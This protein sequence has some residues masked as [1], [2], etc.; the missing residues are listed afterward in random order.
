MS[1]RSSQGSLQTSSPASSAA[2]RVSFEKVSKT[3]HGAHGAVQVVNDVSFSLGEGDFVSLI[4]PSGCGKTTMLQMLAGF[5]KPDT[6]RVTINGEPVAGPGSDRGVIFQEYGVFP[7]LTVEKN[8]EFG[9]SL[10]CNK[11]S[12]ADRRDRLS[13]RQADAPQRLREGV[14]EASF[15]RYEAASSACTRL[16]RESEDPAHGR[17]VWGSGRA[18]PPCAAAPADG[19]PYRGTQDGI[20]HYAL[21]RGSDLSFNADPHHQRSTIAHLACG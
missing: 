21:R 2:P 8:I 3:Y 4:G 11:R 15:R 20:A 14:S 10:A 19:S 18:N 5:V 1:A 7:W 12:E 13:L 16:C 6:G 17:A 9:L